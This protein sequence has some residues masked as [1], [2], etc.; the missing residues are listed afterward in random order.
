MDWKPTGLLEGDLKQD[1]LDI[2]MGLFLP[3]S[4]PHLP[5]ILDEC[6]CPY[7]IPGFSRSLFS[8]YVDGVLGPTLSNLASY[9]PV[10]GPVQMTPQNLLVWRVA[11]EWL[12]R[13]GRRALGI[14]S[15]E[16]FTDE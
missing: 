6:Y 8:E 1:L 4:H 11:N 15:G 7:F 2:G 9:N 12:A 3:Y 16:R 13:A 14:P 10:E 5:S